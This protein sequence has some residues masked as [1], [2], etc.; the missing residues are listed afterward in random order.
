M[1]T[2]SADIIFV[3]LNKLEIDPLNVRKTYSQSSIEE[4]AGSLA[5]QGILQNLLVRKAR[6]NGRFYVSA[7]GRRYR[8]ALY[9]AENDKFNADHPVPVKVISK[10]EALE[11]S[12]AENVMREAMNP[13]D[14]LEAYSALAQTGQSIADIAA[15][16]GTTETIVR[17]RLALGR[18]APDLLDLYRKEEMSFD[19]LSAFTITDDHEEQ[20]RV[21]NALPTYGRYASAIKEAL[22]GAGL[23]GTAKRLRF[24]GGLEAYE[25]AGGAVKRDLFDDRSGGYA[26][27]IALVEKLVANKLDADAEAIRAEGWKWVEIVPEIDWQALQDYDRRYPEHGELTEEQAEELETLEQRYHELELCDETEEAETELNDLGEKITALELIVERETYAPED[28]ETA[29][30]LICLNHNGMLR[31]ERGLIKPEDCQ[32]ED[33]GAGEPGKGSEEEGPAGQG[34]PVLKHSA[35]LMEDLTAQKTAAL[36]LELANNPDVALASVVHAL[37]LRLVYTG[38]SAHEQS[39]LEL[40]ITHTDLAGSMKQPDQCAALEELENLSEQHGSHIPGNPADLWDWCIDQTRDQLLNL[41]AWA[42]SHS[43]NAVEGKFTREKVVVHSNQIGA[44]VGI[45]MRNYFKPT[46][47]NYFSHLQRSSIQA[48]VA[49]ACGDDFADGVANMKKAEGVA[50]AQ[51]ALKDKDWLPEPIRCGNPTAPQHDDTAYRFPE[52]A[53]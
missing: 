3:P 53:E 23:R 41:L 22:A 51:K 24:I 6:G 39:A 2:N 9:L 31:I 38:Y 8:A 27:D 35:I 16:F 4:L 49:E 15:K 43:V 7:G 11:L 42:A 45:D 28:I 50:F 32:V 1:T 44:A 34:T 10:D 36:R 29:G 33:A 12:L 19:Q 17:K 14:E 30:V 18:V 20:L 40:S 5:A 52:A 13:A 47:E 37:L 46:A 21:W 25:A 26:M 48:A